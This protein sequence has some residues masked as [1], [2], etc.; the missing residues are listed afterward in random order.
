MTE[1]DQ[2]P[3][4]NALD[5]N[6]QELEVLEY[7]REQK[8]F[9]K[10][11][12]KTK[13]KQPFIFYDGPPFATGTPHYGHILG[14]TVKDAFGR[15]QTMN[16][17][18]VRRVWG[19]D[20]HGLP[21]ENIVEKKLNIS[22]KK[23]IEEIGVDKF[24]EACREN[25]LTYVGE[26]GKMVERMGRWVDFDRSYKTMDTTFMESVWWGLKQV[27]DK[28]L[29]YEDH[30]VLMYCSRC[31]TPLSNFEVAMD[32]SYKDVT[33]ESVFVKFQLNPGQRILDYM[34][35]DKTF[36]L[37]WTTTPWTLPGNT[38][39]NI[40]PEI[41]YVL[42][43][44]DGN[45]YILA[46][47]RLEV[48]DGEY[49]VKMEITPRSLEGLSYVPLYSGVITNP[50]NTAF[51]IY[52]EDYVTTTDGTGVVHNAAMY[53]E[54]DYE[55][56]KVR[57]LPREQMLDAKGEYMK[58][59]P[60]TL[61]GKFFKD[62]DKVVLQELDAKGLVYKTLNF[63]HSYPHC[64]RC[65]TPLYYSALPAWFINV[66]KV[67]SRMLELNQDINWYPEH[68]KEGR[69]AQG[70]QNAP[71]WNISRNRF[72]ATALPFWKCENNSCDNVVCIGS[73]EELKNQSTNFAEVYP[74]YNPEQLNKLDLHKPYIDEVKLKC[75]KC[76]GVMSRVPEVV[77]CWVE[78]ASMPFAELHAPFENQTLFEHR[79]QA[80]FVAEYI[81]QTRAWFY[82]MHVFSTILFD[83]APFKNVVTTG[84]ILAEDGSKMSKS[85]NNF[86]DPNELISKYGM[87][88]IRYYLL[89]SPVVNGED[90]SFSESSVAEVNRKLGLIFWNTFKFFRMYSSEKVSASVPNSTHSLDVWMLS[91]L[92]STH[93]YVTEQLD[94]YNTVKS[95]RA[96]SDLVTELSTWYV[97]RNRDRI[98]GGDSESKMA[99]EVL[100][101]SLVEI[102]KMLAP[103]MPYLSE[104]IYRDLTGETSVHLAD[105]SEVRDFR[106]SSL[107]EMQFVRGL[108]ELGLSLRKEHDLKVRQPL[109]ELQY[110]LGGENQS[111]DKSLEAI[112]AEELNVKKVT[113]TEVINRSNW[114]SKQEGSLSVNLNTELTTELKNEGFARELERAVQDLRK[115]S[116]LKI[117]QLVDL[118]YTT[119]NKDLA[120][121]LVNLVD[122]KKTFLAQIKT[123]LEVE[124][125]FET[126]A[127]VN[128]E[129]IWLGLVLV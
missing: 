128:G 119:N 79:S 78:S 2:K 49:E 62:G 113:N 95:G 35:D 43:E 38:A 1:K 6:Q 8:M 41:N 102:C 77:D 127:V 82:V 18:F 56:A 19:W 96:I 52:I 9:E 72:W 114:V 81:P 100:G 20:C 34:V 89:T 98:K 118:Y 48:L 108:V 93:K 4:S 24:N 10:S 44:Q 63:T 85:K 15:Y 76:S 84:T 129:A 13:D 73:V 107:D 123:S 97:R 71:D 104:S 61:Q 106:Q 3:Q 21:I 50:N 116:G 59:V 86:P 25:V 124:A 16:G 122:R 12:E 40:G 67:K 55:A 27:W 110:S 112:L 126:Q 74:N 14:S 60:E 91:K 26:W 115:K 11:L 117:G 31:E 80:D 88:P 30:K 47:E 68:L 65:S 46:R 33:E 101:F 22:G 39:L 69:F 51:K 87:D 66:Q 28:G 37:A 120:D 5:F 57:N 121:I 105:W 58:T 109:A 54:V 7:W 32:N 103:F 94:Q 90:L 29:I 70:I 53:G 36:V 75:G 42:V 45:K 125:D 92:F 99:L 83:K 17:R 111:L 64:W 23:Q